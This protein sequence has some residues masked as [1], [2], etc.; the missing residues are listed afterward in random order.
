[1]TDLPTPP[2]PPAI[3]QSPAPASAETTPQPSPEPAAS[4]SPSGSPIRGIVE[5]KADRQEYD[6]NSQTVTASGNVF[7]R[8]RNAEMTADTVRVN[9]ST[10]QAVAEGNVVLKRGEQILR[11]ERFEYDLETERGTIVSARGD[12]YQ[13][14]LATDLSLAPSP[15]P[16][17]KLPDPPISERLRLGLPVTT[18]ITTGSSSLTIGADRDI[19]YQPRQQTSD[20]QRFRFQAR[21]AEIDRQVVIAEGLRVT[22]DPFSPP[23]LELRAD[24]ARFRLVSPDESRVEADNPRVSLGGAIDIPIPVAAFTFNR[25][26]QDYNPWNIGFDND[27]RGGFFVGRNFD[28]LRNR[29]VR[30]TVTPQFFL[31]RALRDGLFFDFDTFG[32]MSDFRWS[33]D[34]QRSLTAQGNIPGLQPS[35]LG[36]RLRGRIN[37][38]QPL[39]VI[40]SNHQLNIEAL[41]RERS[42]NGSAGF[43]DVQSLFGASLTSPSINLGDNYQLTYRVGT[44]LITANTDRAD[45][46]S[47]GITRGLTTLGR[48]QASTNVTRSFRLWTGDTLPTDR[49]ETFNYSPTAVTPYLQ[50]NTNIETGLNGYTNGETQS[51]L[52]LGVSLQ[53][54]VGNFSRDS[55]DYTGFNIGYRHYFRGGSSPFLFDRPFDNRILT[56]G[57]LQQIA[58]PWRLGI[59]TSVNLDTG[60]QI[61]TD[62]YVEYS[63]RTYNILLRYNPIL[64]IGSIGFRLNNFNWNGVSDPF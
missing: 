19:E 41:Y 33:I 14:S 15:D 24:R 32:L 29:D 36:D 53:G 61:S 64:Q 34:G 9:I 49:R 16:T 60:S 31:Q 1:M 2:T 3:V 17:G 4:P 52:G 55:F 40:G 46:L 63:R 51:T 8:F 7:L 23:E 6:T 28:I 56:A 59:Q 44:Q 57:V 13:P 50:L 39:E 42:F 21:Q 35:R 58:G 48:Y 18:A 11:G 43:Q 54:Q 47:A 38:N 26:G 12:I 62:Y 25:L 5:L 22:N 37:Y 45:L 30:W 20:L 10:R 27:E